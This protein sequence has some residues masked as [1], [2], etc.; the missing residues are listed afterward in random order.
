MRVINKVTVELTT[1]E[2]RTLLDAQR[3]WQV[4]SDEFDDNGVDITHLTD[5]MD[6]ALCALLTACEQGIELR[7]DN[8]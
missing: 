2:H 8:E 4:I 5:A 3:V 7:S 1:E 6:E